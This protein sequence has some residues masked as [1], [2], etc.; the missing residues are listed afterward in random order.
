MAYADTT[1]FSLADTR[2]DRTWIIAA[3]VLLAGMAATL[4][5]ALYFQHGLG[6][7][8]C[9]LCLQ[10]REGYYLGLPF[11]AAGLGSMLL[12]GPQC[13][14]RGCLAIAGLCMAATAALGVYHAG[15]EWALW[16]GPSDCAG[17][18]ALS[19]D[20]GALL[21]SLATTKPPSCTDAPWRFLGL[22]FAGWNVVCASGLALLAFWA[23]ARR[24]A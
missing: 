10:Q 20:A 8:P 3:L 4:G 18:Q 13:L 9:K 17:G 1:P 22:S 24:A 21:D 16:A 14:T 15:A 19:T 2:A 23:T 11:A 6:Y 5:T 7:V 12:A